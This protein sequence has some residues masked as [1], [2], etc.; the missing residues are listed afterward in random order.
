MLNHSCE[1]NCGML[2]QTLIIAMRDIG[3]GEEL[4][5]DSAVPPRLT[6]A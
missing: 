2:G 6:P 5:F 1:P 3:P 4:C